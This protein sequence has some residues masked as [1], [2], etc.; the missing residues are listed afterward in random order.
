M[1]GSVGEVIGEL[2][3]II[4]EAK[5]A[6]SRLG[7]F[8]ALYRNV[9]IRVRDGIA[10]GMFEDGPRMA[11]LD[12]FFA[13][14]YLDAYNGWRNGAPIS[15]SWRLAFESAGDF[16]LAIVQHLLLGIS[17]HINLDLGI[18]TAETAPG[19]AI[20][21]IYDDFKKISDLLSAMTL[22]VERQVASV[23]PLIG[24]LAAIDSQTPDEV[25]NFN[26]RVAR[27]LAW[28]TA[29]E[30]AVLPKAFWPPAIGTLDTN[31]EGFGILLRSPGPVVRAA[32]LKIAERETAAP[33]DVIDVLC[34]PA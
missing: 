23:S 20:G 10:S 30:F 18:A 19:L 6:N 34:A 22:G 1:A 16:S 33:R 5:A 32:L 29:R 13:N 21:S 4:D 11:R 17:A 24:L 2:S 28:V 3:A 25:A 15:G 31:T 12:V 26:I 9:T 27:D 7:Y 8:P 14:R